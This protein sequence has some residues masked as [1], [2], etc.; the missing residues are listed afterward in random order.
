M[1]SLVL[2][3]LTTGCLS[4]PDAPFGPRR[5]WETA[6]DGDMPGQ[7]HG[8][9]LTYDA[10][11]QAV[12]MYAG[13]RG[14][15]TSL[16][17]Q[18]W[19]WKNNTWTEICKGGVEGM[20]RP[21]PVY[22]PG[23]AW[24]PDPSGGQ[25]VLV[26]G[27]HLYATVANTFEDVS[28]E[29]WTCDEGNAWTKQSNFLQI[30]R[31]GASLLYQPQMNKL[32]LVGGRD[33]NRQLKNVEIS[34]PDASNF[35]LDPI[36]MPFASAGAGQSA[37]Y[38]D[39]S[40]TILALETELTPDDSIFPHDAMWKYDGAQWT[41]F[42]DD[43]SGI[44][45]S[46]ASLVHLSGSIETYLIGGYIGD[47]HNISG[48]WILDH[49]KFVRVFN[50]PVTRNA[51]GVVYSEATD[52]LVAHGGASPDCAGSDCPETLELVITQPAHSQ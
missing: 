47:Q 12:V 37:T 33:T 9:K 44:G 27:A 13:R 4:A 21:V 14:G 52:T 20:T 23:F 6:F 36:P 28:D 5:D 24:A 48:T 43:C 41:P 50:D 29:I 25:L 2:A 8:A 7:M 35:E 32:V 34:D 1:K 51:I 17:G 31:A 10:T 3:A 40:K 18:V 46:D 19:M 39:D 26:G 15:E 11:R 42:C 45:R 49:E 22:L 38:D 30:G 16:S